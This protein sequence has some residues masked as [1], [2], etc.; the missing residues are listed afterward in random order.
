MI[1]NSRKYLTRLS[2]YFFVKGISQF[3][4]IQ[5][6][7][8]SPL[9][10]Q[11]TFKIMLTKQS[12]QQL[13]LSIIIN[14]NLQK[15]KSSSHLILSFNLI[16]QTISNQYYQHWFQILQSKYWQVCKQKYSPYRLEY[17]INKQEQNKSSYQ[18]SK[19]FP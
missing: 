8:H 12:K 10:N 9:L 7:M 19:G 14:N 1:T 15:W 2:C 17:S 5:V 18:F 4:N 3:E 16:F 6:K 13:I 11:L